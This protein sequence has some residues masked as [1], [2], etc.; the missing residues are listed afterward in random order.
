[1]KKSVFL[2]PTFVAA[3]NG[4]AVGAAGMFL[5]VGHVSGHAPNW[6]LLT[7]APLLVCLFNVVQSI[8]GQHTGDGTTPKG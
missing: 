2:S 4:V 6:S 8:R 1:M 5:L 3:L 7:W